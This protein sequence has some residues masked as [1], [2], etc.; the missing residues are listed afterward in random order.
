MDGTHAGPKTV[1]VTQLLG[2]G[3]DISSYKIN[4]VPKEDSKDQE[5]RHRIE[6]LLARCGIG[7][8]AVILLTGVGLAAWH[9]DAEV[10][11]SGV[12]IVLAV[13]TGA[14]GFVAGR[15]TK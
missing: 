13:L 15:G 10:R 12:A 6:W 8:V 4:V 11:K 1:D 7:F 14:L 3:A 9:S 5:H 2:A